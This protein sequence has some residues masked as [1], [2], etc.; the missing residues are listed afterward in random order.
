MDPDPDPDIRDPDCHQ[1]LIICSL[2]QCQ[3]SLKI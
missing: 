1:N 2:A 3:P